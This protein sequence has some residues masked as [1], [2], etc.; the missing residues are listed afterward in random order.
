MLA[1]LASIV[2]TQIKTKLRVIV[3]CFSKKVERTHCIYF[4]LMLAKINHI[5][6]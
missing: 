6:L 5:E 1:A 2:S 4:I 3:T